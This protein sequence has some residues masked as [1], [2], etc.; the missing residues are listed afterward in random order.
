MN[1]P[2]SLKLINFAFIIISLFLPVKNR[3]IFLGS[4]RNATLMENGQLVYDALNC[5][6][7]II[8]KQMPH[9][10]SDIIFI[11]F[12]I[13]TSKV[14]VIDDHYVYSIKTKSKVNS[15]VAWS[16]CF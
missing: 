16:G 5:D 14:L 2:F 11:S 3:V 4:P 10:I 15:N 13:M 7:K 1:K 8:V 6:K 12:F 9:H